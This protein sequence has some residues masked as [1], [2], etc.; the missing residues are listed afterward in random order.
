MSNPFVQ[1]V[2][3][4]ARGLRLVPLTLAHESGLRAAAADGEL[5]TLRVTGVPEPEQTRAYI[6]TALAMRADGS[7]IAFAVLDETSGAVLGTTSFHDIMPAVKRVEIGWTWYA[8]SR[9]RSHVNTTCKLLLLTHA[10]ETLGCHV[11]GWRTDNFNVAS[12]RAIER[13][14]AKKDGVIRGH[15]LRRDGTIR[16]TVMYSL[17]SGEWPEVKA[18]LLYLLD[19]PRS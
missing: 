17:R 5:W 15:A 3:L 1:P 11:V 6:D 13:L 16:D 19:K 10:F 12:Q 9:Q 14:G 18:Q 7:R 4:G 8:Q 2:E